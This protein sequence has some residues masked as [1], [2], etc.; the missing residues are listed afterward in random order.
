MSQPFLAFA[1]LCQRLSETTKKLEKRALMAAYLVAVPMADAER[2]AQWLT[3]N[4]FSETDRRALNLGGASISRV[5]KEITGAND[6]A[7][8]A[9]YLRHGDLGGARLRTRR[10]EAQPDPSITLEETDGRWTPLPGRR[11]S[12]RSPRSNRR[13]FA[14][15]SSALLRSKQNT[16]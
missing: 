15:C 6:K 4:P 7:L 1:E 12:R 11:A 9:A 14:S 8:H 2:A 5:L 3:G 13:S 16:W 10:A